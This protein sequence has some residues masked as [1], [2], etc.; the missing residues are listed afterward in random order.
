MSSALLCWYSG[1]DP[2]V[3]VTSLII[4]KK[5]LEAAQLGKGAGVLTS[6]KCVHLCMVHVFMN[7]TLAKR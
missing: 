2:Q 6:L 1:S 4:K 3:D 7:R 5:I